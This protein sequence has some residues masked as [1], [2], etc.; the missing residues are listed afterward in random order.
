MPVIHAAQS[1]V[2]QMHGTSFTSY[3]SPAHGSRELCAWRIEIPGG[4]EGV[5]HHVSREE[6]LY[7]LSGTLRVNVDGEAGDAAAGD[8]VLVPAGARFGASNLAADPATAWVTTTVGFA[9]VLPD[10]SWFTPPWTR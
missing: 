2:H 1:V 6:V 4:T 9:G 5:P 8:V 10:G 3:A 7:V